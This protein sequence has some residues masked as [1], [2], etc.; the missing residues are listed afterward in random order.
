MVDSV[1]L[2]VGVLR[3]HVGKCV[4]RGGCVMCHV[5]CGRLLVKKMEQ[6][7]HPTIFFSK[8]RA[9]A[10]RNTAIRC[11]ISL[12]IQSLKPTSTASSLR[13]FD[14]NVCSEL[15]TLFLCC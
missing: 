4:R 10:I 12:L 8:N 7:I 9:A 3:V 13:I 14:L 6:K 1:F 2:I 5:S 15:T 11:L